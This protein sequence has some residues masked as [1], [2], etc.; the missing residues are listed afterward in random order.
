MYSTKDFEILTGIFRRN[1]P[2]LKSLYLFGSY[3]RGE[4]H[5]KSDVDVAA[6]TE[7]PF[8][9]RTKINTLNAIRKE[10]GKLH[11]HIDI[12]V[13]SE[14]D[15]Q[16]DGTIPLTLSHTIKNEGTLLWTKV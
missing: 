9:W 14:H 11:Y 16:H 15:W 2:G 12:L 1:V 10:T 7:M 13:K 3:A 4:A 8:D 6:I 5:E